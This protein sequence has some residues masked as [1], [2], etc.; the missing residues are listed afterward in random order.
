[1]IMPRL[2]SIVSGDAIDNVCDTNNKGMRQYTNMMLQRS[3]HLPNGLT[4]LVNNDGDQAT[5]GDYEP[6]SV[7]DKDTSNG[8]EALAYEFMERNAL[9]LH[10]LSIEEATEIKTGLGISY[11][12][13]ANIDEGRPYEKAKIAANMGVAMVGVGDR[14]LQ[15]GPFE[16]TNL[17]TIVPAVAN[18]TG[19]FTNGTMHPAGNPFWAGRIVLGVGKNSELVTEG[20]IQAAALCPGGIQNADNV[21]YNNYCLVL[22][23]LAATVDEQG[24]TLGFSA[25]AD[26][27]YTVTFVDKEHPTNG[28]T[29]E[30]VWEAQEP[31]QFEFTCPEGHKWPDNDNDYW[32]YNS[33]TSEAK[34]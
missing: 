19:D 30:M 13:N 4:N 27:V 7:E 28:E 23:R 33:T 1:M 32:A 24:A 34:N 11:V 16:T 14:A 25:V 12:Y 20:Y 22:P 8:A 26:N 17:G 29:T 3:G 10:Q 6:L 31:W 2:S 9:F 5:F 18:W 21:Q 15:E